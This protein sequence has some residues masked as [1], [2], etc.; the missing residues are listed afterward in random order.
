MHPNPHRP[1]ASF[2][3][4]SF[5]AV[6]VVVAVTTTAIAPLG[7][8]YAPPP[9]ERR[10]ASTSNVV[11]AVCSNLAEEACRVTP[12][13]KYGSP[14]VGGPGISCTMETFCYASEETIEPT[15]VETDAGPQDAGQSAPSP[16]DPKAC[17][18]A[19]CHLELC[20]D[21]GDDAPWTFEAC[22][23]GPVLGC[24]SLGRCE[25][26]R[27]GR[28]GWTPTL[29]QAACEGQ[30]SSAGSSGSPGDGSSGGASQN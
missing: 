7:G 16:L 23:P 4:F 14:C 27:N 15:P 21:A 26:Q 8:C 13:C 12:G 5:A 18:R 25:R 28:C 2:P 30:V 10:A 17:F 29:E 24:Q 6:A 20:V 22:P 1:A 3:S 11:D 9:P 19:G